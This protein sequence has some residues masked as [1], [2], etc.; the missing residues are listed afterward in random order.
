MKKL[1]AVVTALTLTM[2]FSV[3]AFAHSY[4]SG[5][6]PTDGEVKTEPVQAITLNFDEKIMEGS[7]IDLATTKGEA[8][9]VTNLEIGDGFLTGRVAEPLANNDYT[10]NWS[11]IS[12]DGHPLEGSFSFTVK[13][14]VIETTGEEADEDQSREQSSS[15]EEN[16][17]ANETID[18]DASE[19]QSN[20]FIFVVLAIA[21]LLLVVG[22]VFVIKRKK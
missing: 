21:A 12:A 7:F 17:V 3:Q 5:S 10:V 22:F 20:S 18:K 13:V 9:E 8:I 4:L 19:E 6:N 14:P 1:I 2:M 15:A 11:I 16:D